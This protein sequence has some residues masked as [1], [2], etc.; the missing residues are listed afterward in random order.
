M[1]GRLLPMPP[2]EGG[3][4]PGTAD[5]DVAAEAA[6]VRAGD[7]PANRHVVIRG[8]K[9]RFTQSTRWGCAR[10][11]KKKPPGGGPSSVGSPFAV[12]G[13]DLSIAE[14]EVRRSNPCQS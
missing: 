9:K 7:L 2:V 4:Y 12:N 10:K 8:L 5:P 11:R 1:Q 3:V 13:V 6:L 14:N